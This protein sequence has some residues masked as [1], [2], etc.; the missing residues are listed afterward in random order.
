MPARP[1]GTEPVIAHGSVYLRPAERDDLDLFVTWLNDH[2]TSRT[3]AL[4][5]PLSRALEERWF[6]HAVAE[7]GRSQYH[8]VICRLD[9]ARPVGGADLFELDLVNGNAG[10]GIV[11]GDQGDYGLA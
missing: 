8:F 2:R 11:I 4:R 9:D 6:E 3:L 5:A 7:Q 1:D 10:L